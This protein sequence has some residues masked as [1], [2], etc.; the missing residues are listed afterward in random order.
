MWNSKATK[1]LCISPCPS[2][3]WNHTVLVLLWLSSLKKFYFQPLY[4]WLL[5][6]CISEIITVCVFVWLSSSLKKYCSYYTIYNYVCGSP[7]ISGGQYWQWQWT[8]AAIL[9]GTWALSA[10][11]HL[12]PLSFIVCYSISVYIFSNWGNGS[13]SY[14]HVAIKHGKWKDFSLTL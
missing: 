9:D 5:T 2:C 11:P 6:L 13:I 4:V 12:S 8:A 10:Q 3:K 14:I 1:Q 7:S